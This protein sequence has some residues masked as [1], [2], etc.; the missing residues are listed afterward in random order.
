MNRE[1]KGHTLQTTALI[2]QA[3]VRLVDQKNVH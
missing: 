2:N 3:Y 1:R